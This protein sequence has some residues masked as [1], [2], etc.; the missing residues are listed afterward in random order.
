MATLIIA[1][2]TTL[3][4]VYA[5]IGFI[6]RAGWLPVH[7][8][9]LH[10]G[11]CRTDIR[12]RRPDPVPHDIRQ[13]TQAP[14]QPVPLRGICRAQLQP[15]RQRLSALTGFCAAIGLGRGFFRAGPARIH[16]FHVAA[17]PE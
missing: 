16:L 12:G 7:R 5:P 10:A 15:A 4:A 17:E 13:D 1:M 8:V 9:C 3:V 6:G 2:T 11:R 14:R